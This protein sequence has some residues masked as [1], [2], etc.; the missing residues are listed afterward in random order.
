M[1]KTV[2]ITPYRRRYELGVLARLREAGAPRQVLAR[3]RKLLVAGRGRRG[4]SA[5]EAANR[6][7]WERAGIKGL[8]MVL[9]GDGPPVAIVVNIHQG[10]PP[11]SYHG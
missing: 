7:S 8:E 2:S 11:V 5:D 4:E 9:A 3:C 1:A 10:Q 6:I